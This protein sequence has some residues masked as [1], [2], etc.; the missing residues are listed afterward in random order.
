MLF[1]FLF[2]IIIIL[3]FFNLILS[4]N[5]QNETFNKTN[6]LLK[7]DLTKAQDNMEIHLPNIKPKRQS[8]FD[9]VNSLIDKNRP[10]VKIIPSKKGTPVYMEK[11]NHFEMIKHNLDK[12]KPHI[13]IIPSKRGTPV[14][15]EKNTH[16]DM[17]KQFLQQKHDT[18]DVSNKIKNTHYDFA[19]RGWMSRIQKKKR[20]IYPILSLNLPL[21]MTSRLYI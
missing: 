1:L 4:K 21:I 18:P 13:K 17:V 2:F 6:D 12:N 20:K 15:M 19:S 10:N 16:F 11:N 5:N 3:Y 9:L 8:P 14:Q 7:Y